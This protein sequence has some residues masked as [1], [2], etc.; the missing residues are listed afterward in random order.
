MGL[1]APSL[2]VFLSLALAGTEPPPQITSS[3]G[4]ERSDGFQ[5][6]ALDHVDKEPV[7]R[8]R[9]ARLETFAAE[10][11]SALQG[12]TVFVGDSITHRFPLQRFFRGQRVVN[13]GI[14]GDTMGGI[15]HQGVLN[16]LESTVYNLGPTRI[17]LMIAVNDIIWSR[18][19][20][21]ATKLAQYEYLIRTIRRDRPDT[22]LWCVSVLPVRGKYAGKNKAIQRFN[23]YAAK[24]ARQHGAQ[25]LDLYRHFLNDEG[26]LLEKLA[27]DNVHLSRRGYRRL[28]AY[29]K[30]KIFGQRK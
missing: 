26:E 9:Q 1:S 5:P 15:R 14:G 22:E 19:T 13:R 28:A 10:D 2:L 17:I 23:R 21:F 7:S 12:T 4:H 25:W 6:M 29:Y 27:I 24:V 11:T 3:A 18:G 30:R 8:Y 16:R 20:A